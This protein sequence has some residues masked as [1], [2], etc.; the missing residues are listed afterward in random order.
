[1]ADNAFL[2]LASTDIQALRDTT[3]LPTIGS[4]KLRKARCG[5]CSVPKKSLCAVKKA[6]VATQPMNLGTTSRKSDSSSKKIT[7]VKSD[8]AVRQPN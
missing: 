3:G 2:T 1:M 5:S 6:A 4:R 8:W 7:G